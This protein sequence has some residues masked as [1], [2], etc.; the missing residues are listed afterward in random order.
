MV[1]CCSIVYMYHIFFIHSSLNGHLSCFHVLAIV[2][3]AAMNIG[4][5]VS[6]WI[7]V[8]SRYIPRSGTSGSYGNYNFYF[9]F[10]ES[11]YCFPVAAP[12]YIPTNT[13]GVSLF[14]TC[15]PVFVICWFLNDGHSDWY[16]MAPCCSY[17]LH[18][19]NN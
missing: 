11:P 7:I 10:E 18:F 4:M 1:E 9:L 8:L 19:S 14:S 5:H 16:E 2:N 17:D 6:F 12:I 13:V 15:S 3:S